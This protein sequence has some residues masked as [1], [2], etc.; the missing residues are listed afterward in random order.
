MSIATADKR[1]RKNPLKCASYC[2]YRFDFIT[3]GWMC[4][5]F[6]QGLFSLNARTHNAHM[7]CLPQREK[8]HHSLY[9]RI[10]KY[11]DPPF[12]SQS[13]C[14]VVR[15]LHIHL[16]AYMRIVSPNKETTH[17]S[18]EFTVAFFRCSSPLFFSS[19]CDNLLIFFVHW[20]CKR[21]RDSACCCL[22]L[23]LCS[24]YQFQRVLN[25]KFGALVEKKRQQHNPCR[26]CSWAAYKQCVVGK[27][28]HA[29]W[30]SA[31][32]VAVNNTENC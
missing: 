10:N 22:S 7:I 20:V 27:W 29:R 17:K 1:C 14:G 3:G 6:S 31:L 23:R 28:A 24:L 26:L 4:F 19:N 12:R 8:K 25:T 2:I 9:E 13:C 32:F 5:H 21:R 16:F 15:N 30:L 11:F 18:N